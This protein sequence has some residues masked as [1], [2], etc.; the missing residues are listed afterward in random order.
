MAD[1]NIM[2]FTVSDEQATLEQAIK[3]NPYNWEAWADL[4]V[5]HDREGRLLSS[6]YCYVTASN[7]IEAMTQ[8]RL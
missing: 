7:I 3:D 8:G 6:A 5:V 4:A 2:R 1:T